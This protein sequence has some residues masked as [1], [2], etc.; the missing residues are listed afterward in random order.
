MS[1]VVILSSVSDLYDTIEDIDV[2]EHDAVL[3]RR[4]PRW[5]QAHVLHLYTHDF[6]KPLVRADVV[7]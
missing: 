2:G 7:R 3:G 1:V 5:Y 4:S 6:G